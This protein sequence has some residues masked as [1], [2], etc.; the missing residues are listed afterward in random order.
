MMTHQSIKQS[1]NRFSL[2]SSSLTCFIFGLSLYLLNACQG[3]GDRVPS[4]AVFQ[5]QKNNSEDHIPK[6]EM[7]SD[8]SQQHD[9][10][11]HEQKEQKQIFLSLIGD[12]I[13][14]QLDPKM[15]ISCSFKEIRLATIFKELFAANQINVKHV[16]PKLWIETNSDSLAQQISANNINGLDKYNPLEDH[17]GLW[18]LYTSL[19]GRVQSLILTKPIPWLSNRARVLARCTP[20]E[21]LSR[22]SFAQQTT[23]R[24]I[25]TNQKLQLVSKEFQV[26]SVTE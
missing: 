14:Q 17:G 15:V 22:L 18:V 11:K 12:R 2:S 8:S 5:V 7:I 20:Q 6:G 10:Q 13:Q 19:Q 24:L 16:Q 1:K 26:H 3:L 9:N 25:E 21:L 23:Q 4:T